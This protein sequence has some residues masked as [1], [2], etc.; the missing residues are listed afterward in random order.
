M[1]KPLKSWNA[2]ALAVVAAA[3]LSACGGGGGGGG[4][5]AG[6]SSSGINAGAGNGSGG[7][8]SSGNS[9]G[10]TGGNS[11]GSNGGGGT[12]TQQPPQTKGVRIEPNDNYPKSHTLARAK[13]STLAAP[14]SQLP[15][16]AVPTVVDLG[17]LP[18]QGSGGADDGA[19]FKTNSAGVQRSVPHLAHSMAG[20]LNWVTLP[21]ARRVAA[22]TLHSPSAQAV[23]L[24]VGVDAL[25]EGA[26]LRFYGTQGQGLSEHSYDSI[27]Q[28]RQTHLKNGVDAQHARQVF[29]GVLSG[30]QATL[31]IELPA[32]ADIAAV[33]VSEPVLDHLYSDIWGKSGGGFVLK[34]RAVDMPTNNSRIGVAQS[35][36]IN[37][38][39]EDG[40]Y[41][42]TD[43]SRAVAKY[44]FRYKT[45][46]NVNWCSGT[47]VN[48]TREDHTPYFLTAHHCVKDADVTS[49]ATYWFFRSAVCAANTNVPTTTKEVTG[50]AALL[51]SS[52]KNDT[53]LLRLNNPPPR[54]VLFSGLYTG[55]LNLGDTIRGVHHPRGD[56]QKFSLGTYTQYANASRQGDITT[57]ST[58]DEQ[59]K[60]DSRFFGVQWTRGSTEKGSSGHG[61]LAR[62]DNRDYLVGVFTGG[63]A[64]CTKPNGLEAY[65]RL[66]HA[67]DNADAQGKTLKEFLAP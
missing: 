60:A 35:C 36:H 59:H 6:G 28:L 67:W 49:I 10:N 29:S 32:G 14:A 26:T 3:V 12:G 13:R 52:E 7:A 43:Q 64:D 16:G 51:Y 1:T 9:S 63:E 18:A 22:V 40:D 45:I 15:L 20:A 58:L 65:G 53:S 25:P 48:N 30:S 37:I 47:L 8:N 34:N 17:A 31:E 27:A 44:L 19:F 46:N 4:S 62:R 41:S 5:D 23:R 55:P 11:G 42:G 54:G 38:A 33:R 39:C 21:D 2:F 61:L 66:S 56:L 50:G 57:V 24:S